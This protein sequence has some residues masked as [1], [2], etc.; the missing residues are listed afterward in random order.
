MRDF[1][2][3]RRRR[4]LTL[5]A[6]RADLSRERERS[7]SP[8]GGRGES[9]PFSC[10]REGWGVFLLPLSR[11]GAP[12][13]WMRCFERRLRLRI[14]NETCEAYQSTGAKSPGMNRPGIGPTYWQPFDRINAISSVA[15]VLTALATLSI[16]KRTGSSAVYSVTN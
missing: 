1:E 2:Q 6:A 8:A 4:T 14:N 12:K 15:C 11:E 3:R 13:G 10:S 9:N 7:P 5:R 16:A